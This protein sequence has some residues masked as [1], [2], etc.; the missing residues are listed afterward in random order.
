MSE[1]SRYYLSQGREMVPQPKLSSTSSSPV[2]H[3][4]PLLKPAIFHLPR[5]RQRFAPKAV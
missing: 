2:T 5:G 4:S 3:Y 1:P